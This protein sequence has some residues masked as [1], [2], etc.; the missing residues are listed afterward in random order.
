MAVRHTANTLAFT[1]K[2]NNDKNKKNNK[3]RNKREMSVNITLL[4][5][6]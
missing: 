4:M 3:E 6:K 2:K 1:Q 5:I